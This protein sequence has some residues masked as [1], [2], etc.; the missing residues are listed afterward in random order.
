MNS[1]S[2]TAIRDKTSLDIWSGGATQD[3]SLLPVFE[4][5]TYFSA[6]DGKVNP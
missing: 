6:K 5:P 2:L 4:I 3:Y 1:L